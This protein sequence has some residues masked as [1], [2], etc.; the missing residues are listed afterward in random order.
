MSGKP[1]KAQRRAAA[2]GLKS[3][4]PVSREKARRNPQ[5]QHKR[6]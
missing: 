3:S 4:R 1:P 2:Q 5:M 6:Q